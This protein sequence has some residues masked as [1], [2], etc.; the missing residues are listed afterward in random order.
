MYMAAQNLPQR[1]K[2]FD[3]TIVFN[4]IAKCA[5][6]SSIAARSDQVVTRAAPQQQ[7]GARMQFGRERVAGFNTFHTAQPMLYDK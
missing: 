6:T 5:Q 4:C 2:N 3:K 7:K 1:F